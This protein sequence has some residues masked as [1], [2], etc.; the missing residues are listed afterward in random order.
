MDDEKPKYR[1]RY[2]PKL[3]E[4]NKEEFLQDRANGITLNRIEK[5]VYGN[6]E[7]LD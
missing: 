6:H 4:M 7:S 2:D 1:R 3:D 5:R